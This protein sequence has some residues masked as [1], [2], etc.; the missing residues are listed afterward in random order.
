MDIYLL[1]NNGTK[2]SLALDDGVR[3]THLAAQSGQENNQLNWVNIVGDENQ[4]S[5]LVLN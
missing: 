3:D 5:L 1:V 2:S 4:G